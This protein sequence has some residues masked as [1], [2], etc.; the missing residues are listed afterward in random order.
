MATLIKCPFCGSYHTS[1]TNNGKL[2]NALAT[3]GAV[4]GGAM[5]NM[6][7]GGCLGISTAALIAMRHSRFASAPPV[8]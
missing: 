4:V 3:A 6:V 8:Q 5:I 2:S 7:T 1:K